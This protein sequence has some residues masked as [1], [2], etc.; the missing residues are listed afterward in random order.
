MTCATDVVSYALPHNPEDEDKPVLIDALDDSNHLSRKQV[1]HLVDLLV[2]GLVQ[3]GV[4]PGDTVCLL[5]YNH[6][7]FPVMFLAIL[8][9]GATF[10]AANPAYTVQEL[11]H[12]IKASETAWIITEPSLLF[13][14][15]DA[16]RHETLSSVPLTQHTTVQELMAS[17]RTQVGTAPSAALS[18]TSLPNVRA[19][20][21]RDSMTHTESWY[22]R[23][24]TI[25]TLNSTSGTTGMPKMA[26][27]SHH[28]LIAEAESIED[29]TRKPYEVRRL[30]TIPFF[31][32]FG[33]PL[34]LINAL[35]FGHT[36]YVMRK[37]DQ[38]QYLAAMQRFN[39]TET[40]MPPPL[41]LRF[42]EMPEIER[43]MLKSIRQVWCGGA[44]ISAEAQNKALGM[45]APEARIVQVWGMT[46]TGWLT[47]FKYPESDTT[48][49]VG[50]FLPTF[51]AK[52]VDEHGR[53]LTQPDQVGELLV[54]GASNMIGYY[55]NPE[56]TAQIFDYEGWLRTG[57][58]G[59][60]ASNGK[61]YIIDRLKELIKVRG[62][63]VAPAE[64]E[65]RLL[66]HPSIVDAAVIGVPAPEKGTE[67]PRAYVVIR[68]GHTV[69]R[70]QLMD[71]LR[72]SLAKYKVNDC[73]IFR[74]YNIPKSPSGKILRKTI[75]KEY[76]SCEE[77]FRTVLPY[78]PES[79]PT[80]CL[81]ER[82]TLLRQQCLI[83]S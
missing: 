59:R 68:E 46:E 43:A 2:R 40:A 1:R 77:Q 44:P 21:S 63:Q 6:I 25:A 26:A 7:W 66:E 39:I 38:A 51:Q 73:E 61:V 50:R 80:F 3:R 74:C 27:R 8:G 76:A 35:R 58:L 32:A 42:Q 75:R 57:D 82:H 23:S 12:H 54:K 19:K 81:S 83:N 70:A 64:I 69:N 18:L 15:H 14:A 13:Q 17:A 11:S 71:H 53:E 33:A 36:T 16:A 62:W 10:T 56:A 37:F 5:M 72:Q 60:I 55:N 47:T 30:L 4:R 24:H 34:A 9:A 78:S 79:S 22:S 45:F 41:L 20:P 48:G 31:H 49:S 67:I 52:I 65:G 28:S 29:S